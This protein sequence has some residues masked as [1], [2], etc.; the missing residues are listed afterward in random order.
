MILLYGALRGKVLTISPDSITDKNENIYYI[1]RVQ[2]DKKYF[3]T[4]DK[5][6]KNHAWYDSQCWYNNRWKDSY[7]VYFEA[8]FKS[9]TVH[10]YGALDEALFDYQRRFCKNDG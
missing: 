5:P 7:A 10:I 8:Y 1:V 9:K 4:E 6:L 2:T 3:G